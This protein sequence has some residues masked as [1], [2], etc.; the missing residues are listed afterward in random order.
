[1]AEASNND[2]GVSSLADDTIGNMFSNE[3]P[4]DL[5]EVIQA[6]ILNNHLG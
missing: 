1:M 5:Q 6:I 4:S 2:S 3:F